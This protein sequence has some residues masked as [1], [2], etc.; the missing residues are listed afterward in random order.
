MAVQGNAAQS[1][2]V[3]AQLGA[4]VEAA[5]QRDIKPDKN[6]NRIAGFLG[7]ND[8][9]TVMNAIRLIGYWRRRNVRNS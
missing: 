2:S 9:A 1:K 4:L 3:A 7:S 6:L 8:E 5:R